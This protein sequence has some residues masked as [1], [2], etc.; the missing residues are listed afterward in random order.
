M[1]YSWQCDMCKRNFGSIKNRIRLKLE[2]KSA[3]GRCEYL[4]YADLC[5][6]CELI[7]KKNL[8]NGSWNHIIYADSTVTRKSDTYCEGVRPQSNLLMVHKL[9]EQISCALCACVHKTKIK[10]KNQNS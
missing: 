10:R 1:T 9:P 6:D 4:D 3:S 5:S 7:V 8:R 2:Q